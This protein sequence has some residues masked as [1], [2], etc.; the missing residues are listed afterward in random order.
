MSDTT[1][2]VVEKIDVLLSDDKNFTTRTGLRFTTT[3]LR[4]A[5]VV[6]GDVANKNEKVDRRLDELDKAFMAFV[7]QQNEKEK[8]IKDERQKDEDERR[9]WRWAIITPTIGLI[10]AEIARWFFR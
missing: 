4:D 6:I 2:S 9:K 8:N 3:V 10:V 7:K 5:M 1:N